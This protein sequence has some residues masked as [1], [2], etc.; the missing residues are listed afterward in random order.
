MAPVHIIVGTTLATAAVVIGT[1]YV[2]KKFI[3]DPHLSH[4]VEAFL[5]SHQHVLNRPHTVAKN[6]EDLS[7]RSAES[8]RAAPLP[9]SKGS[10]TALQDRHTTLRRRSRPSVSDSQLKPVTRSS[11]FE[12]QDRRHLRSQD[13]SER[14]FDRDEGGSGRDYD[15]G[16]GASVYELDE[17]RLSLLGNHQRDDAFGSGSKRGVHP[18]G[19]VQN[20]IDMEASSGFDFDRPESPQDAEVREVIFKLPHTPDIQSR[21]STPFPTADSLPQSQ[22][23]FN[24]FLSPE[25]PST[26]ASRMSYPSAHQNAGPSSR[27]AGSLDPPHQGLD[28]KF[29]IPGEQLVPPAPSTTFSFLSL[30]QQSSPEQLQP[31]LD[32]LSFSSAFPISSPLEDHDNSDRLNEFEETPTLAGDEDEDDVIS[33]PETSTTSYEDAESYTPISRGLSPDPH[34]RL[35][36]GA[37][38]PEPEPISDYLGLSYVPLAR[39]LGIGNGERNLPVPLTR[40]GVVTGTRGPMSVISVSGSEAEGDAEGDGDGEWDVVSEAGR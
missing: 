13:G 12:L 11:E 16:R 2:F 7:Y 29:L 3:Y 38:A 9:P 18:A 5:A 36:E 31:H 28:S 4:H 8:T 25:D 33:L 35:T 6:D 24:P 19:G 20:L 37:V 34:N 40:A 23:N 27:N 32:Q 15:D 21:S 14:S 1:G 10:T 30:S 17:S 26:P 39:P 22:S